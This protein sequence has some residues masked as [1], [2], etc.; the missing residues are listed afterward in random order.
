MNIFKTYTFTWWQAG[1][2]KVSV[3]AL[4]IAVGAYWSDFFVLHLGLLVAIALIAGTYIGYISLR[5]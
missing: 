5:Q 1:I 3:G 4:G 2:F